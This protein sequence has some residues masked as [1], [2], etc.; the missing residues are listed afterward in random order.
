MKRNEIEKYCKFCEEAKTLSD[1]DTMICSKLGI[2][3]AGHV[4]RRFKYDPL[5]RTPKRA[6]KEAELE[7]VEV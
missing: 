7:Y 2:V 1:P 5:K 6:N 4:C 3:P